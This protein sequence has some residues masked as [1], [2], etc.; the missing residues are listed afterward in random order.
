[1]HQ[2]LDILRR[3]CSMLLSFYRGTV[4]QASKPKLASTGNDL[5]K[6]R[7]VIFQY[8]P[9]LMAI[10]LFAAQ[11]FKFLYFSRNIKFFFLA[12]VLVKKW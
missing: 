6:N 2:D 10:H 3:V 1:M 8:L 5:A 4:L 9:H 11:A 12:T 7:P